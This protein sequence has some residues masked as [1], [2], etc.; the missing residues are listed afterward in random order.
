MKRLWTAFAS[1]SQIRFVKRSRKRVKNSRLPIGLGLLFAPA[2]SWAYVGPGLGAGAFAAVV[3]ILG[4]LLLLVWG[5]I[6]YPLKRFWKY[7]RRDP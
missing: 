6:W 5:A 1:Y 2:V 7:L 4:G 3:G